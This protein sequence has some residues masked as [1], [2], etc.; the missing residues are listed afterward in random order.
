MCLSKYLIIIIIHI[1]LVTHWANLLDCKVNR[2]FNVSLFNIII[3]DHTYSLVEHQVPVIESDN[4]EHF[5]RR[6]S[7]ET[8]AVTPGRK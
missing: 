2:D 8:V 7:P 5:L 6:Q 1:Y 3:L 4:T